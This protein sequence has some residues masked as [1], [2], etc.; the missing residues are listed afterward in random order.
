MNSK[1]FLYLIQGRKENVLKY[2][3]LQNANSDLMTLTF[4]FKILENELISI[5]NIFL[6]KSSWA[7]GRNKQLEIAK[8]IEAKY[9]YYIFIDDDVKFVKG[10][11][12]DF[13]QRLLQNN[14]AI[15]LPL[16]TIIKRTYRFNP[17]L[18]IQHPVAVDQQIQ[19]YHYGVLRD[20][21]VMP[22]ETKFDYLSWWYSCEINGFLILSYYRG[23][24]MQFNDIVVD[25]IGHH[26]DDGTNKSN[27]I[28]SNYLG[29]ISSSGLELVRGY[30]EDKYGL[31]P[32]LRNTLFHDNNFKKHC[33]LP[34]GKY[35]QKCYIQNILKVNF[36]KCFRMFILQLKNNFKKYPNNLILNERLIKRFDDKLSN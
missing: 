20:S 9:L 17:K 35:L 18:K 8:K 27:D 33:Y 28:T 2:S 24:I 15:G 4:D 32:K 22:L 12:S 16:L 6:P 19:A 36:K 11:F 7:E 34:R 23:Y 10:N 29:G 31:Q 3:Y 30:I 21:I 14:P 13:E 5:F 1:R 26:W 25:N